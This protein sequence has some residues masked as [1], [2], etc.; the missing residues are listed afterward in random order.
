M[1]R[2]GFFSVFDKVHYID[3]RT[4]KPVIITKDA[5]TGTKCPKLRNQRSSTEATD[6]IE[7]LNR[8]WMIVRYMKSCNKDDIQTANKFTLRGGERIKL[9]RVIFTVK[10]LVNDQV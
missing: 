10:E 4:L 6:E 2:G 1:S 7:D 3:P 9:G 5:P 8:V